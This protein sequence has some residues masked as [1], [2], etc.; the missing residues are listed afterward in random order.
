[1]N[2][3]IL[4]GFLQEADFEQDTLTFKMEPGYYALAGKWLLIPAWEW[5]Q[6]LKEYEANG[7]NAASGTR[8]ETQS[9]ETK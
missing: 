1:M 2:K 6:V 3:P 9:Q 5:P 7:T 8:P 4:S